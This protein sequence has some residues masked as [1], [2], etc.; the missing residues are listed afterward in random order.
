MS[1]SIKSKEI[2]YQIYP[3]SFK[4]SSHS[5]IGDLRGVIESLDYIK[6]IGVTT[7]WLNPIF[8]S[9]QIDNGY[10]VSDYESIDPI[11]GSMRDV[12]V[13]IKQAHQRGLKIMFD[14]VLNHTS[15]KHP[16]FI[17]ATEDKNSL[18]RDFYLW[19]DLKEGN[20][21]PNNWASFF[22]GPVWEREP[23]FNQV[24]FHLFDKEMPDLNWDNPKVREAM[25]NVALFWL[26][27]GVDGFRLDAFIHMKKADFS[28]IVKEDPEK[29]LIAEEYYANLPEVSIYLEEFIEALKKR[30]PSLFI[31]GEAASA[32]PVLAK[33]YLGPNLCDA[34]ISFDHVQ[35]KLDINEEELDLGLT[36]KVIDVKGIKGRLKAWQTE[37]D[38]DELP[39]LYWN[40]HDMPRLVSRFGQTGKL[41]VKSIKSLSTGMYLLRGIPVILYG[42]EIGMKNLE[43]DDVNTF[44][45]D[46]TR[47]QYDYLIERG[48]EHHEA[49]ER[50]TA[51]N[52]EASRGFMQWESESNQTN[53][54]IGENKEAVFNVSDQL[55]SEDGVLT[56]YQELFSLKQDDL[57]AN[58]Q[59]EF[60]ESSDNMI[61]YKR[62]L[63]GQEALIICEW[64][65]QPVKLPDVLKEWDNAELILGIDIVRQESIY[66]YD[67][68][69]YLKR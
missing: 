7:I 18:Y 50:I 33:S 44:Y 32:T 16:W 58:A 66:P 51:Q 22:G 53:N 36:K 48:W 11:F 14:L 45:D 27:K 55:A 38:N 3:K 69:V 62:K 10:D 61:I 21:L 67:Y 28:L 68:A 46:I 17:S 26:E 65:N 57:F 23:Y 29:T 20:E 1:D 8:L 39:S 43:I 41:R 64:A 2:I 12:E 19:E 30:K 59:V 4:D 13:L 54:W 9:P 56:H 5:G 25:L 49:M 47:C 40:N 37:L 6:Q 24:Y 35:D 34:V 31:L 63:E 42:E 15:S 52:K 60:I